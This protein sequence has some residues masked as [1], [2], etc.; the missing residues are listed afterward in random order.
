MYVPL[1]TKYKIRII[2][3]KLVVV[4]IPVITV[5]YFDSSF[6]NYI[7]YLDFSKMSKN[8]CISSTISTSLT[9][10]N[11]GYGSNCISNCSSY[12]NYEG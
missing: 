6:G 7:L 8:G 2:V 11:S 12:G 9:S 1:E 3:K 4:L 10:S 5:I